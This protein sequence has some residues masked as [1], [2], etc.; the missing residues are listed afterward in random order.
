MSAEEQLLNVL[1]SRKKKKK[2]KKKKTSDTMDQ[3]S[4]EEQLLNIL[5]SR[6][7]AVDIIG[8]NKKIMML[9]LERIFEVNY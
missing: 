9:C 4:A 7:K 2:K 5:Q 6:K 8:V 3:L 1:Q